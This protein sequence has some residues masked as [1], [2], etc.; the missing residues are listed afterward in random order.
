MSAGPTG[1]QGYQ[2]VLGAQ[3]ATG[4]TGV[5]TGLVVIVPAVQTTPCYI[6]THATMVIA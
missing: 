1:I 6:G 4:A 3:G 5:G 2:G